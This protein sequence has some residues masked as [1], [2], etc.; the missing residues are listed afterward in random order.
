MLHPDAVYR[1]QIRVKRKRQLLKGYETSITYWLPALQQDHLPM[2]IPL[3][4]LSL[5]TRD[6]AKLQYEYSLTV[7]EQTSYTRS[8]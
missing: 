2:S 1:R 7:L 6:L 8:G 4:E 3:T 5:L